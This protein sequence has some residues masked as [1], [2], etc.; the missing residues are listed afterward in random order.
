VEQTRENHRPAASH[1]QTLSYKVVSL[2]P[3]NFSFYFLQSTVFALIFLAKPK[4]Q[5]LKKKSIYSNKF[6]HNFHL[7]ESSFTCP[8]LWASGLKIS[9]K[10]VIIFLLN[11]VCCFLPNGFSRS[12]GLRII[13]TCA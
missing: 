2:L 9:V 5:M 4:S 11:L 13:S 6:F 10:T 3:I 12:C 7:S 1:W 8:K